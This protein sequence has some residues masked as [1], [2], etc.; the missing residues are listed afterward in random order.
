MNDAS[1]QKQDAEQERIR[2]KAYAHAWNGRN[3]RF[4]VSH[5]FEGGE[6]RI[7]EPSLQD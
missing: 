6:A 7:Q 3:E 4:K 5:D 2:E 1:S